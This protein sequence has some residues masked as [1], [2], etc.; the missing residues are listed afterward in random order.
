MSPPRPA[1]PRPLIAG[2]TATLARTSLLA[3]ALL[4]ACGPAPAPPSPTGAAAP[5]KLAE[6]SLVA[7]MLAW[8]W[9]GARREGDAWLF[10]TDLGYTVGLTAAHVGLGRIEMVPCEPAPSTLADAVSSLLISTAH[11]A[12]ARVGDGSAVA[13]PIVESLLDPEARLYGRGFAGPHAYCGVHL[14]AVPLE[15]AADDGFTLER[16]SLV[17]TGFWSAPGSDQRHELDASINL[18][19]GSLRPLLGWTTWPTA[20][21]PGRAPVAVVITRHPARAFDGLELSKLSNIDLA[22]AVLGNLVQGAKA[23]VASAAGNP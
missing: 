16:Q 9:E 11:A 4:T 23:E 7:Y 18:Q 3:A 12:H 14:L 20:L 13:S 17:L 19:D 6:G 21:K 1:S 10:E 22:F 5:L 2:V 8:S 15:A